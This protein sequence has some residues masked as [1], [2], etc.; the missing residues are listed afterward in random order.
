MPPSDELAVLD[1]GGVGQEL[2]DA[3]DGDASTR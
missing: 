3:H 1:R 2:E